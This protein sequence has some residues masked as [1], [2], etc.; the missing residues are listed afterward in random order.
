MAL[1]TSQHL[2]LD[3]LEARM[4]RLEKKQGRFIQFGQVVRVVGIQDYERAN[5]SGAALVRLTDE[6]LRGAGRYALSNNAEEFLDRAYYRFL[7]SRQLAPGA[8][9]WLDDTLRGIIGL[10]RVGRFLGLTNP[11]G[12]AFTAAAQTFLGGWR[13]LPRNV[14]YLED[15]TPDAEVGLADIWVPNPGRILLRVPLVA[16]SVFLRPVR[17]GVPFTAPPILPFQTS[18]AFEDRELRK[19]EVHYPSREDF[20]LVVGDGDKNYIAFGLL[21]H[22]PALNNLTAM[23]FGLSADQ[24]EELTNA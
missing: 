6:G 4:T 22:W 13:G 7:A 15:D 18:L 23:D 16:P 5:L 12:W 8:S 14:L 11:I 17:R 9:F 24:V 20:V 1:S 2:K 3:D 10:S 19:P 21:I